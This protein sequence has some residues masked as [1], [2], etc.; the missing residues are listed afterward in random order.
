MCTFISLCDQAF[1]PLVAVSC[2]PESYCELLHLCLCEKCSVTIN[3]ES[4]KILEL[5][6]V[7]SE[8]GGEYKDNA[9]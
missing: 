9:L 6:W 7:L 3:S 2:E 5:H 4:V 1:G 8:R